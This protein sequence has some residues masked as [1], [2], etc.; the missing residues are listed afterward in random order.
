[1]SECCERRAGGRWG[2]AEWITTTAIDRPRRG[3]EWT[4]V[5]S[6]EV[7]TTTGLSNFFLIFLKN[8]FFNFIF[9]RCHLRKSIQVLETK[10][11]VIGQRN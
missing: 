11:E 6:N 2:V 5:A 4:A 8:V 7:R 10:V 3:M 1:V 9:F